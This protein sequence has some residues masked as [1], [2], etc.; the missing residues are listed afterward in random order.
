MYGAALRL[1]CQRGLTACLIAAAQSPSMRIRVLY[2]GADQCDPN[3]LTGY[4]RT[5][6]AE[7]AFAG[8]AHRK[9]ISPGF[10]A[11]PSD[12]IRT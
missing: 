12:E 6:A 10:L 3:L 2:I 5:K 7:A 11:Q 8:T 9:H 4:V 1:T